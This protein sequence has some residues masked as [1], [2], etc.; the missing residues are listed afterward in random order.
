LHDFVMSPLDLSGL[1]VPLVT[2]FI[3]NGDVDYVSLDRLCRHVLAGG[4]AGVCVLGTTGEP[5]TL[6]HV[7]HG[8]V[9][10]TCSA[11]C[12][13]LDRPM[14][15]G[16]GTNSTRTTVAAAVALRDVPAVGGVLVVVPYYS[17]PSVAGVVEHYRAVAG[18]SPVPVVAYNVPYRTGIQLGSDAI[19]EIA[20]IPNVVGLKQSVGQLDVD[21]LEI[22]RRRPDSFRL[23]AGDDA[24]IVPTIAMG[25]SGAIAAAAHLCTPIFATMIASARSSDV[26]SARLRAEAL[27]PMVVAGFA[28]PNPAVWK[29]ALAHAGVIETSVVRAPMQAASSA[30]VQRLVAAAGAATSQF[31][32]G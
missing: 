28:E 20:S 17:R 6:D 10:A 13:E 15:V 27:L 31:P 5:A 14:L 12:V 18:A 25:G 16:V 21:T 30:A 32:N 23:L 22:L 19:L 3:A 24:F 9:I 26:V 7:E 4:A 2:P 11:V 1:W 8:A 29:A